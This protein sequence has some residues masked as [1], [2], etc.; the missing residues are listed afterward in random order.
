MRKKLLFTIPTWNRATYL[1]KCVESIFEAAKHSKLSV[2]VAISNNKSKDN[3]EE[4]IETLKLKYKSSVT[5]ITQNTHLKW[6]ESLFASYKLALSHDFDFCWSIGD[7]DHIFPNSILVLEKILESKRKFNG[8]FY[9]GEE[10]RSYASNKWVTMPLWSASNHFGFH[11]LLGWM[12]SSIFSR[13][14]LENTVKVEN[15]NQLY[16][17][18]AYCHAHAILHA[19]INEDITIIDTPMVSTQEKIQTLETQ[20][21]WANGNSEIPGEIGIGEQYYE[22]PV[23]KKYQ[24]ENN[25]IPNTI[26]KNFFRYHT[27]QFWDRLINEQII[28]HLN[29]YPI[30]L[31][32]WNKIGLFYE[33][34]ED[35][36]L[37]KFLISTIE[38]LKAMLIDATTIKDNLSSQ[39]ELLSSRTFSDSIL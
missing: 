34:I 27:Y 18:S 24:I 9:A 1:E 12:S 10:S 33:C 17:K 29:N 38:N 8:I 32:Q 19:S 11:E 21:R 2:N 25:I 20:K 35:K 37:K 26:Q 14:L 6:Y 13:K 7:D 39:I 15:L 16:R 36:Q 31:E 4:I 5:A 28:K 30:N 3:T 23:I 22:V